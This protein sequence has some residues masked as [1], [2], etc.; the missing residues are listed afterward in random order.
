MAAAARRKITFL[1]LSRAFLAI[2]L[3]ALPFS[4]RVV[5]A[6]PFTYMAGY[7]S[8]PMSFAFYLSD[9]LL[10]ISLLFYLLSQLAG[11]LRPKITRPYTLWL[12]IGLIFLVLE[13]N[14]LTAI[15]PP[16]A[17]F[18]LL[19][20]LAGILLVFLLGEKLLPLV[21]ICKWLVAG[22]I[23]QSIIAIGQFIWQSSLGLKILGENPLS[24]SMTNIAKIPFRTITLL[25]AYGT[26]P[27]PNLL[28]AFLAICLLLG[29][30]L[31]LRR[32]LNLFWLFIIS[33]GLLLTF[34]RAVIFGTLVLLIIGYFT[35]GRSGN[36]KR[37]LY[38][39]LIALVLVAIPLFGS[40]FLRSK[41]YAASDRIRSYQQALEIV[42]QKPLLGVGKNNYVLALKQNNYYRLNIWE[43]Q[44]VHNLELLVLSETG[45]LGL[46]AFG[47]LLTYLIYCLASQKPS[48]ERTLAI[49]LILLL[50][51]SAQFDH[52]FWD[53]HQGAMV[54]WLT[55][56]AAGMIGANKFDR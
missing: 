29:I 44:P 41:D 21:S 49:A 13:I 55:V 50:L 12:L 36:F 18:W 32:E 19:R 25:R 1:H 33:L 4:L 23:I 31:Y 10:L 48:L 56:G 35:S 30:Y 26:L 22:G 20:T 9:I 8:E 54:M 17:A 24:T 14:C 46:L 53:L 3:L 37:I 34:S 47:A 7:F 38:T 40:L 45:L 43:Y 2:F 42:E 15:Y 39:G 16:L 6:T 52:F 28:A 5:F 51:W 27:H 11:E